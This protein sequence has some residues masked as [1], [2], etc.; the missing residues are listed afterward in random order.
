MQKNGCNAKCDCGRVRLLCSP[1]CTNCQGQSCSN[2]RLKPIDEDSY[3]IDEETSDSSL[4]KQFLNIQ[5]EEENEEEEIEE[6]MTVKV[7]FEDTRGIDGDL[8]HFIFT[9]VL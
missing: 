1:A 2:V 4:V 9:N 8:W 3:D 5:Q 6:D 7:K